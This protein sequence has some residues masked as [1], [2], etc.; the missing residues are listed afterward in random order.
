MWWTVFVH[1]TEGWV[2][3]SCNCPLTSPEEQTDYSVI[4][5]YPSKSNKH[6][7]NHSNY[8]Y[9]FLGGQVKMENIHFIKWFCRNY[10]WGTAWEKAN[11]HY[12]MSKR[13]KGGRANIV[14]AFLELFQQIMHMRTPW[15]H[16][17]MTF[18]HFGPKNLQQF[19]T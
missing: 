13:L 11:N 10:W 3:T 15:N 4:M 16:L 18:L 12:A 8:V 2:P 17:S 1:D 6:L 7:F 5:N 14:K 19:T 9:L